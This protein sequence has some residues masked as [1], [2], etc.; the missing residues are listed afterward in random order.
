MNEKQ[1]RFCEEY[2][3]DHNATQAA[4]RSGYSQRSAYSQASDLLR[5]PEVQEKIQELAGEVKA[6]TIAEATEVLEFFTQAMRGKICDQ[7]V[8]RDEEGNL[9]TVDVQ[10][11]ASDR[12]RAAESLAKH[13][14]LLVEKV[15][16]TKPKAEL[17]DEIEAAIHGG[18]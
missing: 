4:I 7:V 1:L 3:K 15:E 13:Y 17:A 8:K 11:R 2:I 18:G 10:A 16:L 14:A 9:H 6:N 12:L 5:K